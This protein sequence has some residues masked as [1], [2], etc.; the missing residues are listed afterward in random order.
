AS[1]ASSAGGGTKPNPPASTAPPPPTIPQGCGG[2]RWGAITSVA[3]GAGIGL[4]ADGPN[5]GKEVVMG[6]H[7]Q[8][9]WVHS[10]S[11]WDTFNPCS[12]SG[13][14]LAQPY[15]KPERPELAAGF[16]YSTNWRLVEAPTSGAVYIKDYQGQNCLTN[17][18]A[19]KALSVV[20][21]TPGNKYQQWRIP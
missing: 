4:V 17:N 11:T 20:S 7:T 16:G 8:Y 15:G 19:G 2:D 9:G 13:P 5:A 14:A 6:G 18:G 10:V 21:C 3:D 1:D 12:L